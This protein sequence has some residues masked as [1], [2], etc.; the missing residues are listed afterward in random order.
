MSKLYNQQVV[1]TLDPLGARIDKVGGPMGGVGK[2]NRLKL[3]KTK[4]IIQKTPDKQFKGEKIS[5]KDQK[6]LAI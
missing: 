5:G 6:K 2:M 1:A 4:K 3:K